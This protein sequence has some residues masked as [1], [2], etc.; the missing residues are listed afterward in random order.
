MQIRPAT[1]ADQQAIIALE[2]TIFKDMELPL[3]SQLS[4]QEIQDLLYQVAIADPNS[5]CSY[6]RAQVAVENGEVL[7]VMFGYPAQDEPILDQTFQQFLLEKYGIDELVFPDSEVYPNEWYLDSLV[8][9]E[10]ARGKG[11]GGQLL[12]A[13]DQL[14]QAA[15]LPVVGLNVDDQNPKAQRLYERV[16]FETVGQLMIGQHQYSHMQRSVI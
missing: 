7:G 11:I 6:Q 10:T 15:D 14:A 2:M 1:I 13:S 9:A 16:G 8:V 3:L 4:N 12:A 5:R